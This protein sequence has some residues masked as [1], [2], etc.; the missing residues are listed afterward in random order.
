MAISTQDTGAIIKDEPLRRIAV[1]YSAHQYIISLSDGA[2]YI[3][4][5]KSS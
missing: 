4:K 5:S 2:V 1:S 3:T